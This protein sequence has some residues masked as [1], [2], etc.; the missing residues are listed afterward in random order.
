MMFIGNTPK[1]SVFKGGG[2]EAGMDKGVSN[3][4]QI[5]LVNTIRISGD[6]IVGQSYLMLG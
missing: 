1:I 6:K 5:V 4:G 3:T 2:E